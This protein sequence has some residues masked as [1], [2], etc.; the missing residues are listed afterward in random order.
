MVFSERSEAV[1]AQKKHQSVG[2]LL[3]IGIALIKFTDFCKEILFK[4]EDVSC[5]EN[6]LQFFAQ[7]K[8]EGKTQS[9]DTSDLTNHNS[10]PP[11]QT[12]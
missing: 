10:S 2:L 12:N 4:N 8:K 11:I 5:D 6:K 7:Q 1:I 3:S 9:A